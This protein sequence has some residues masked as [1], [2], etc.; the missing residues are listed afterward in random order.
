MLSFVCCD[1]FVKDS[2]IVFQSTTQKVC[3]VNVIIRFLWSD[4]LC[5]YQ[6][7]H[8][9]QLTLYFQFPFV[10]STRE[11][12][13]FWSVFKSINEY[14]AFIVAEFKRLAFTCDSSKKTSM[15]V[16][17]WRIPLDP[18]INRSRPAFEYGSLFMSLHACSNKSAAFSIASKDF[19]MS[20]FNLE[21]W[22]STGT[23]LKRYDRWNQLFQDSHNIFESKITNETLLNSCFV[24]VGQTTGESF[25][26]KNT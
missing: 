6:S 2:W 19:G 22:N 26:I 8:I 23:L 21:S 5:M 10:H 11:R 9:K 4:M 20:P 12:S 3:S 16:V 18:A 25:Y 17:P 13:R 24:C 15:A 1:R 7:D 14:E